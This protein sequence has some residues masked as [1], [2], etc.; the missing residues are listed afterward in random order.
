VSDLLRKAEQVLEIALRGDQDVAIVMEASGAIRM[1]DPTG[2]SLVA[3]AAESGAATVFKVERRAGALRVEGWDGTERCLIQRSLGGSP[4]H[5]AQPVHQAQPLHQAQQLHQPQ[6]RSTMRGSGEERFEQAVL[7]D[8]SICFP[9]A[10]F[11]AHDLAVL[12][13]PDPVDQSVLDGI[14]RVFEGNPHQ[15]VA[16]C[17]HYTL[18]RPA[19]AVHDGNH[20]H[21]S[22]AQSEYFG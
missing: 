13:Y 1:L 12:R 3:L 17:E 2:W 6:Q 10:K 15:P 4:L 14:V 7:G 20:L 5:Q 8:R 16:K 9:L 18:E 11:E 19:I 22:C 21:P